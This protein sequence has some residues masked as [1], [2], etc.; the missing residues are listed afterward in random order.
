MTPQNRIE[1]YLA[2]IK[3]AWTGETPLPEYPSEPAWRI[4]SFLAAILSAVKGDSPVLSCPDPV[5]DIPTQ[6]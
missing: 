3:A 1:Q 5:W 6:R 4:E 2:A